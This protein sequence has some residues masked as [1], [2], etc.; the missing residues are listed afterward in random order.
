MDGEAAGNYGLMDQQA[1]MQWVKNNIKLFGGNP[2]NICLMGYGTGAVSVGLHMT[3]PQSR[4]LFDKAIAM[5]G[6][7]LNPSAVKLPQE[8]RPLLDTLA[9]TF[10]C[11]RRPTALLME[12]L[13]RVE[14]DSLVQ[15]TSNINWRPLVDVGLSNNTIPFLTELPRNFYERGDFHKVPFLSGYTDMEEVLSIDGLLSENYTE[16]A[17][18][19]GFRELMIRDVPSPNS[20][21][22]NCAIN[23]D[24][25][26]NS[27]LFFYG[28]STLPKDLAEIRKMVIDFTTEKNYASSTVLHASYM[29][30]YINNTYVYRFD[31]KPETP[32]ALEGLPDWISVPHLFDLIYVWGIPYWGP[33]SNGQEWDN[34]DKRI[35]DIIMSFWTNFA[36]YSSP[37]KNSLYAIKWDAFT[38]EDPKILMVDGS[39][40]MSNV[41][42][43]NYK[44]FEFWNEYYP[45]VVDAA[46]VCCNS[47]ENG[48]L[49]YDFR[50]HFQFSVTLLAW[51]FTRIV[52]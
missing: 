45:K 35:S 15:F 27:I 29:S 24:F 20:T 11:I 5:S 50:P 38:A 43:L 19:E 32:G 26:A 34:R 28:P 36:K 12:C 41:S 44:A 21:V 23:S 39:F 8:D 52:F 22:E 17:L 37:T 42:K 25:I 49:I 14:A 6:N 16:D 47:T 9:G 48:A 10:G 51:S 3:N 31:L 13:R 1:A 4:E 18:L 40:A 33:L 30:R 46:T 7:F 2:N